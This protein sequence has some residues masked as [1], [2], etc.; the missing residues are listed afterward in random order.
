M[1]Q[2][3]KWALQENEAS[4]GQLFDPGVTS[5]QCLLTI[6]PVNP[7]LSHEN[8]WNGHQLNSP[9]QQLKKCTENSKENMHTDLRVY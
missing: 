9:C 6:S 1:L 7:T 5:I 8:K 2:L 3:G 4:V